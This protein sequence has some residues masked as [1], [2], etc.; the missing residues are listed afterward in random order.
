MGR[1]FRERKVTTMEKINKDDIIK[2]SLE[3]SLMLI[4]KD[5]KIQIETI[6]SNDDYIKSQKKLI[7][8]YD[9]KQSQRKTNVQKLINSN[10]EQKEETLP[11]LLVKEKVIC[12]LLDEHLKNSGD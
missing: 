12:E 10:R 2:E 5:V 9:L 11:E 3:Q 7:E 1:I 4:R 6:D 8:E